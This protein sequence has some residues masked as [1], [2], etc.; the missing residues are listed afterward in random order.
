[1]STRPVAAWHEIR[2]RPCC[3]TRGAA[4]SHRASLNNR[5]GYDGPGQQTRAD[6]CLAASTTR[7]EYS[8]ESNHPV[9]RFPVTRRV[10]GRVAADAGFYLPA[11]HLLMVLVGSVPFLVWR[12]ELEGAWRWGSGAG[13][14]IAERDRFPAR[15]TVSARADAPAWPGAVVAPLASGLALAAFAAFVDGVLAAVSGRRELGGGGRGVAAPPGG[16]LARVGAPDAPAGTGECLSAGRAGCGAAGAG[17]R[18]WHRR[19][20]PG[21]HGRGQLLRW[22]WQR[23]GW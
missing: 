17:V 10:G 14:E 1:M 11:C 2:S 19:S 21:G 3:R 22:R 5:A 18:R 20:L 15:G 12:C 13:D 8:D 7:N 9:R 16:L 23:G 6:L 4:C